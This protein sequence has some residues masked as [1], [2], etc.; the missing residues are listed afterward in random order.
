[1]GCRG[2]FGCQVSARTFKPHQHT[3]P[4]QY[5]KQRLVLLFGPQLDHNV[6]LWADTPQDQGLGLLWPVAEEVAVGVVS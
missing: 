6:V 2:G 4:K 5:A 3:W 1:M